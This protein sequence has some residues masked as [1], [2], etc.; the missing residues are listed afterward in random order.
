LSAGCFARRINPVNHPAT[1][2]RRAK[3]PAK[4]G[5]CDVPPRERAT[6]IG[7]YWPH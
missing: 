3:N 7:Y 4:S 5:T 2:R 6:V 1:L